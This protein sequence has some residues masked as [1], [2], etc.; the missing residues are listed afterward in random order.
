MV[1]LEIEAPEDLVNLFNSKK[2]L[3]AYIE[4]T[5]RDVF[6]DLMRAHT[7][8]GREQILKPD[9]LRFAS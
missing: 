2:E 1:K 4:A 3:E 7:R 5:L 8:T 6:N 9:P